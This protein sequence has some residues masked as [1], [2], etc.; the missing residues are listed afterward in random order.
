MSTKYPREAF[1]YDDRAIIIN[2]SSMHRPQRT[3]GLPHCIR[4]SILGAMPL[5]K[6]NDVKL[7]CTKEPDS[8]W[9]KS[10]VPWDLRLHRKFPAFRFVDSWRSTLSGIMLTCIAKRAAAF[11]D[12][13]NFWMHPNFCG[14]PGFL[15]IFLKSRAYFWK[16]PELWLLYLACYTVIK[17]PFDSSRRL[18]FESIDRTLR[19][20]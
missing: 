18:T 12:R 5:L 19:F 10:M 1:R 16:H 7:S 4:F 8:V 6:N 14:F 20:C 15:R 13:T 9:E 11:Q 3:E 17:V 2:S